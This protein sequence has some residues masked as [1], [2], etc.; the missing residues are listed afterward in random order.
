MGRF[1]HSPNPMDRGRWLRSLYYPWRFGYSIVSVRGPGSGTLRFDLLFVF[2]IGL[3]DDNEMFD[4]VVSETGYCLMSVRET[5]QS[6]SAHLLK[7]TTTQDTTTGDPIICRI[8]RI[9][10]CHTVRELRSIGAKPV[11][12]A[13]LTQTKRESMYRMWNW[14]LDPQ[15]I[16]D[17]KSGI[18][19]LKHTQGVIK[20]GCP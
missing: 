16:M 10:C 11:P 2:C 1:V 3:D 7:M 9:V 6:P 19:R 20:S 17:Q 4:E 13:A 12:V 5:N 14:P 8:T 18:M 15:K